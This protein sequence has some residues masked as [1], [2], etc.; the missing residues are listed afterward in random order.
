MPGDMQNSAPEPSHS[1]RSSNTS[2]DLDS[3]FS[4]AD[5]DTA[6]RNIEYLKI[7]G[8]EIGDGTTKRADEN[9]D[10]GDSLEN[11]AD[12]EATNDPDEA[13]V[14]GEG[15]NIVE[16]PLGSLVPPPESGTTSNCSVNHFGHVNDRPLSES[17]TSAFSASF[18]SCDSKIGQSNPSWSVVPTRTSPT[19][20]AGDCMLQPLEISRTTSFF[21]R[22]VDTDGNLR[23]FS[24]DESSRKVRRDAK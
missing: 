23:T 15:G 4:P 10:D 24:F 16:S 22:M 14:T 13:D 20:D 17:E 21:N 6:T 18:P 7:S 8:G 3:T 2:M 9:G 11:F 5:M 19:K 12:E 1:N